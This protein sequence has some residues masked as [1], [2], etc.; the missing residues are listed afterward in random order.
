MIEVFIYV[1]GASDKL[2]MEALLKDL[3]VQRQ[4]SGVIIQFFEAPSGDKKTSIMQKVPITATNILRNKPNAIVIAMPDLYPYNKAI[5]HETV[6]EL[7]AVILDQFKQAIRSKGMDNDVRYLERFKVFCFKHDLEVLIL[8]AK[9]ALALRLN[10]DNLNV[11]WRIPVEDQNNNT[12]PKWVVMELFRK[13]SKERYS[14][15]VDAPLILGLADYRQIVESCP[16][17][18]KPFI[19]F[20]EGIAPEEFSGV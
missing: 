14:E 9:E 10:Q 16:Q 18:F 8:A 17:C 13:F 19:E 20:L 1:E 7:Q 12:P 6:G 11:T 15:A 4:Q 5:P 2:A 3:I